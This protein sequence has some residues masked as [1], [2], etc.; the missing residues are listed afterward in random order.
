ML[1][2]LMTFACLCV[3]ASAQV[4]VAVMPSYSQS[5]NYG[6]VAINE[7]VTV[8]GRTWGGTAPY[9]YTLDFGDGSAAASGTASDPKFI[10]ASHTY[11]SAGLKT[12][13]LTVTDSASNTKSKTATLR[14]L[15]TP[16]HQ[17][18]VNMAIEKGLLY[19][20]QNQTLPGGE[21]A[22]WDG[23]GEYPMGSNGA[24]LLAFE[25]NGH[26]PGNDYESDVYAETVQR[27]INYIAS[28]GVAYTIS[29]QPAAIQTQMATAEGSI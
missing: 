14:V 11:A 24:A 12:V 27:G 15:L 4:K 5:Q 16:T 23:T 10:S 13:T 19:L 9:N 18:R 7:A 1:L 3:G 8:W 20:Y 21:K 28:L 2:A 29:N 6:N 25:E 22:Y 26:L 17:E